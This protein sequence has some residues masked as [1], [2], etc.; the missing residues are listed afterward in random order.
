MA[1]QT[2]PSE[3][4]HS[5]AGDSLGSGQIANSRPSESARVTP[6]RE[7]RAW[8]TGLR[9]LLV[10]GILAAVGIALMIIW[11]DGNAAG[12]GA[13]VAIIACLPTV[14]GL[15]LAGSAWTSRRARQGKPFA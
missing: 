8:T 13:A 14:V 5:A 3:T 4:R 2:P 7:Q 10:G 11:P 12:W 1:M 6:V 15:A 9:F